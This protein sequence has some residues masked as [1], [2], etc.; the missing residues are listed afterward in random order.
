LADI[1]LLAHSSVKETI[2]TD[3]PSISHSE[4]VSKLIS[5]L[6][7]SKSYEALVTNDLP[8]LVTVRNILKVTH[9]E[10]TSVSIISFSPPRISPDTTFYD[11]SLKLVRNKIRVLPVIEDESVVGVVRQV[12]ILE[13]MADCDNLNKF[14]S[15]DLMVKNLI[16]VGRDSSVGTVRSIMVRRGISHAPIVDQD[17]K[18]LGMI[19]ARDLVVHF[20]KPHISMKVGEKIGGKIR[21]LE[22][23]IRGLADKNPLQVTQRTSILEVIRE[24]IALKKSYSIVVEERKPIGI[25][26]PR[27]IISLLT[28]FRPKIQIPVYMFGFEGQEELIE[29]ARRKIE[30]VAIRGLKIHPTLQEIV[31]HGKVSSGAG[32]RKRFT[33]KVRAYAP[34]STMVAATAEGWSL[35]TVF[36][37]ISKKLDK[38]LRKP[39]VS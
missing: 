6:Q 31:V 19:T 37:E 10:R 29:S 17:G 35:L 1:R 16:T 15:E 21:L 20:I 3:Y 2:E 13:K 4:N 28:E 5:L 30:R 23:G 18:L 22:M 33:V 39:K 11:T 14:L 27:D 24:M 26:T 12:K 32:E 38:L 9:P 25:I 36:D 8:R 7:T 34:S